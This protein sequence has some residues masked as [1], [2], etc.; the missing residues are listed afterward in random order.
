MSESQTV[1]VLE[2]GT[3][4]IKVLIAELVDGKKLN[5]ISKSNVDTLMSIKKGDIIDVAKTYGKTRDAIASA[6]S[7]GS[8]K[9]KSVSLAISG[10]H[11]KTFRNLGSATISS[12][13][14]LVR[15]E[16]VERAKEDA[17]RKILENGRCYIQ[18]ICCGYYLD[19]K[20]CLDP[21]GRPASKIDAEYLMVHGDNGRIV[22]MSNI[23]RSAGLEFDDIILSGIASA[24]A[25]TSPRQKMEGVFVADIGAGTTDYACIKNGKVILAGILPVGGN[26]ITNDIAVGLRVAAR[27]AESVKVKCGKLSPDE[28]EKSK[29]YW[30]I[31]DKQI[32]DK[33]ILGDSIN[34]IVLAR[35]CEILEILCEEAAELLADNAIGEIVLTGGAANTDGIC[36][37]AAKIF[38]RPCSKG[39]FPSELPPHLRVQSW[40]TPIGVLEHVRMREQ[41]K[42]VQKSGLFGTLKNMFFQQ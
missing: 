22:E 23:I 14:G 37:L 19:G 30:A 17:K 16:D 28:E 24:I 18:K 27:T 15:R 42:S 31:G 9:I 8:V 36:D 2:W 39:R 5:I 41:K 29:V 35:V 20:F 11:I 12:S 38:A 33:K 3:S 6:E 40:A 25:V 7:K 21:V 13:D 10:T 4:K 26:H 32:G 1:A 34:K